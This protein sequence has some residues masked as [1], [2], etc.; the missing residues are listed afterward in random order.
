MESTPPPPPGSLAYGVYASFTHELGAKLVMYY[1]YSFWDP[2]RSK[3]FFL[4]D[5]TCH[6][7]AV[8]LRDAMRDRINSG[9]SKKK[10]M[11]K[12]TLGTSGPEVSAFGLGCM[13]MTTGSG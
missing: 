6:H 12:R 5:L 1:G 4:T 3:L 2:E 10:S 7:G 11:K 13:G 9:E 8:R